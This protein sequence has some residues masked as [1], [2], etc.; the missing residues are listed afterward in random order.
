M[1]YNANIRAIETLI[2][3]YFDGIFN[4]DIEQ[5]KSC[6]HKDSYLYGD[7]KTVD[8]VKPIGVYLAGVQDRKSPKEMGETFNM[9]IIGIEI[10]G[11]VAMAKLHVPMLGYNYYDFL[12]L[13][14]I[15]DKW[16][17]VN[18]LFTHVG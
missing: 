14:C 16:I 18:K 4:G 15:E 7:I 1:T 6:F 12:S 11:K 9:S 8:Y 2:Q 10:I 5:L 3:Q 13:A 17:I